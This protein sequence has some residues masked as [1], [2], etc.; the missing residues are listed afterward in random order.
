M[1][2]P[3]LLTD[4]P[5]I[6]N[7]LLDQTEKAQISRIFISFFINT[8]LE[9]S[10][11]HLC[12][13]IW[14][15][16]QSN[17]LLSY[18]GVRKYVLLITLINKS[19]NAPSNLAEG[20]GA[21]IYLQSGILTQQKIRLFP[22]RKYREQYRKYSCSSVWRTEKQGLRSICLPYSVLTVSDAIPAID[23]RPTEAQ[24]SSTWNSAD[25]PTEE[26]YTQ[27]SVVL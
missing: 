3:P 25:Y 13:M 8:S 27:I 14:K 7:S 6:P 17:V 12:R 20:Q 16:Y 26:E 22:C 23:F 18:R 15:Q 10:V 11:R 9:P 19:W 5:G 21:S 24:E 2:S 4:V 1:V